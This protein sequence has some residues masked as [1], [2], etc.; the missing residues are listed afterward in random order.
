MTFGNVGAC[1]GG[2]FSDA[3]NWPFGAAR[4]QQ[5]IQQDAVGDAAIEHAVA[6]AKDRLAP[7]E[8]VIREAEARS[9]IVLVARSVGQAA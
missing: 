5:N 4:I 8:H 9:K 2:G 1:I 7:A 6:T 3:V